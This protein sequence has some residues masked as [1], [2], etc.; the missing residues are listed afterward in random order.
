VLS[1]LKLQ[2]MPG[3]WTNSEK[4]SAWWPI[5]EASPRLQFASQAGLVRSSPETRLRAR[6]VLNGHSGS[7]ALGFAYPY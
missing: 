7:G 5:H 2:I 3:R 1:W 6:G 4:M